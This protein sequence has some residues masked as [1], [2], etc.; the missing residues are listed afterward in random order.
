MIRNNS[1]LNLHEVLPSFE[2]WAQGR[3]TSQDDT[4]WPALEVVTSTVPNLAIKNKVVKIYCSSILFLVKF[5]FY[6]NHSD[7]LIPRLW[8]VHCGM[9]TNM[10]LI[11]DIVRS[12]C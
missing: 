8:R 1:V 12:I 9:P 4:L 2:A 3:M 7:F 11:L 6:I 5:I 10:H